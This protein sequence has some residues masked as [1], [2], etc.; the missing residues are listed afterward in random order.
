MLKKNSS[1]KPTKK[2]LMIHLINKLNVAVISE[3]SRIKKPQ[4][5]AM[6]IGKLF[7]LCICSFRDPPLTAEYTFEM[8]EEEFE[9]WESI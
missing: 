2:Q 5:Q 7:C 3:F 9:K 8:V 1:V 6:L 4:K